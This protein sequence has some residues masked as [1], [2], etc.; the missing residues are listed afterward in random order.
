MNHISTLGSSW[1][2]IP[3]VLSS[4]HV[5]IWGQ[6]MVAAWSTGRKEPLLRAQY[7]LSQL[8]LSWKPQART[9][10]TCFLP[11]FSPRDQ[12]N[13]VCTCLFTHKRDLPPSSPS[14]SPPIRLFS[15]SPSNILV[16]SSH[17]GAP[18]WAFLGWCNL[19]QVLASV[20]RVI[21]SRCSMT[22][23]ARLGLS[24]SGEETSR[25]SAERLHSCMVLLWSQSPAFKAVAC[26]CGA[27]TRGLLE[28]DMNLTLKNWLLS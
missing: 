26:P 10:E 2:E 8:S 12:N 9:P 11:T 17:R 27:R 14:V 18:S 23:S 13:E 20:G 7:F 25:T 5:C 19:T 4:G 15:P 3:R 21:R 1:W 6:E 16:T 24:T 22:I 28:A